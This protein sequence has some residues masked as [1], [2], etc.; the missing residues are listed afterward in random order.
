MQQATKNR[1]FALVTPLLSGLAFVVKMLS[2]ILFGWWLFPFLQWKNSREFMKEVK[3]KWCSLLQ[4]ASSMTVA[5]GDSATITIA[6][7]NLLFTLVRWHDE[8]SIRVAPRHV[9]AESYDLGPLVAAIEHRHYSERDIVHDLEG[10][11]KLLLPR[12]NALNAAF[13][14]QQYPRIREKL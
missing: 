10:A 8:T 14:E 1:I 7:G 9:P 3:L 12:L 4:P 2:I 11:E 13:S 5:S 6:Q